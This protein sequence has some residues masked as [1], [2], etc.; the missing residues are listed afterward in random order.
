MLILHGMK[1]MGFRA[2]IDSSYFLVGL[3]IGLIEV[4]GHLFRWAFAL[5]ASPFAMPKGLLVV[6][7]AM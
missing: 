7:S 6:I 3:G 5:I 1:G 2:Y 4:F